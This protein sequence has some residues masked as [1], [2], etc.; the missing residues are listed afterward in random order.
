MAAVREVAPGAGAPLGRRRRLSLRNLRGE[1]GIGLDFL[2][3]GL[4]DA[5]LFFRQDVKDRHVLVGVFSVKPA[6]ASLAVI[7]EIWGVTER[8]VSPSIP[9][10]RPRESVLFHTPGTQDVAAVREFVRHRMSHFRRL[11]A[12]LTE[13][14]RRRA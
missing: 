8:L 3:P 5:S 14:G 10:S 7:A 1:G 9:E 12:D 4:V 6:T 11:V 13:L 2:S